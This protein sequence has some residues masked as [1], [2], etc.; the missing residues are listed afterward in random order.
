MKTINIKHAVL[1]SLAGIL[2]T[3]CKNNAASF[4]ASGTFEATEI[5]VSS[6]ANGKIE[7]LAMQE[8]DLLKAGE[9]VGYVDSTQLFLKKQQMAARLR[10][11]DIRKPDIHKQIAVLT[12]QISTTQTE[13]RRQHNLVQ[14]KAG[15]Q[16]QLDDLENHLKYLERQLDAQRSSLNK[17]TQGANA[18]VEVIQ[19]QI[20]QLDDLIMKCSIRNPHTGTV[21]VKYAE[22]GEITT[23]GK[24]IYKLADTD[25][26]YLRAYITASQLSQI[27]LGQS[28][29][30]FA[31]YDDDYKE[32]QG[33]LT[34]ISDKAEF[35]P[36]GIQTK[37]ERSNLVYALKVAVKNDGLLKIGQYGELRW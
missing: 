7:E 12:Q 25:I 2:F 11:V 9:T 36:K 35:T 28:M 30:V 21:L 37:D 14:A 17:L 19:Y 18:E 5:I 27:K 16:K 31:D 8:G 32:Y 15:N 6:E 1:T 4:E 33:T 34:W 23:V 20:M 26:L 13:I 29:K 24:P 3:A 22:A 10:S